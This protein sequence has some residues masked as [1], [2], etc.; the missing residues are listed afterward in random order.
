MSAYYEKPKYKVASVQSGP[1]YRDSPKWFDTEATLEK[2]VGYIEEAGRQG[3]KL[4]VFPESFLPGYP[5]FSIDHTDESIFPEMWAKY[6]WSS[7]EVPSRETNALCTAAKKVGTYIAIGLNERDKKYMG[8]MYNSILY[9]S[10]QGKILGTHRKICNTITERLFHTPGDGGENLKA[11][12]ETDIGNLGGSICGEHA[13]FGLLYYW[14]MQ[15]IQIHCSLWPGIRNIETHTDVNTRALCFAGHCFGVLSACYIP[16]KDWPANFCSNSIFAGKT[17]LHGG[18]GIIGP[19]GEYITGPV[20]DKETIVYADVDLSLI[21]KARCAV[22]LTGYYSRWD[23]ISLNIRQEQYLP[24]IPMEI[25]V[26]SST[27]SQEIKELQERI[28]SL[29]Q[30]IAS[31]SHNTKKETIEK[32]EFNK[33]K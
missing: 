28:S 21:D 8:R 26:K 11:V 17:P 29:E 1:V 9:V 20:Y 15:G 24:V 7:I 5:Y 18:S 13:Q 22:N 30:Q 32:S 27:E 16:Q 6:L 33:N 31:L 19:N 3:A 10:P 12:F 25:P 14:I 4:I 23:I 2:A